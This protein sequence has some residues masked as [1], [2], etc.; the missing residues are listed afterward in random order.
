M[1]QDLAI[2]EPV[3]IIVQSDPPEKLPV[4]ESLETTEGTDDIMPLVHIQVEALDN[5]RFKAWSL[6][7]NPEWLVAD[8]LARKSVRKYL[9]LSAIRLEE[10]QSIEALQRNILLRYPGM[11]G[12]QLVAPPQEISNTDLPSHLSKVVKQISQNPQQHF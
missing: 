8:E 9:K 2:V 11:G 10:R 12:F 5:G 6:L 7:P 1:S 3:D 4:L